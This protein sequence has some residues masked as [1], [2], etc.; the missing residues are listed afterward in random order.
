MSSPTHTFASFRL[1]FRL[2]TLTA[3]L[4]TSLLLFATPAM[5]KPKQVIMPLES[6]RIDEHLTPESMMGEPSHPRGRPTTLGESQ[7]HA[8]VL[9]RN[10]R[11]RAQPNPREFGSHANP[12]HQK[13]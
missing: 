4:M 8:A 10:R 3:V 9:N 5:A 7:Q 11:G 12:H 13:K 6:A 2:E 1:F